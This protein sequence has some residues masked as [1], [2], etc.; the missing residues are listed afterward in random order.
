[1]I[2]NS[3]FGIPFLCNWLP[4]TSMGLSFL[5]YSIATNIII[6]YVIRRRRGILFRDTSVILINLIISDL[7]SCLVVLPHDFAFY[8]LQASFP[9]AKQMSK[10]FFVLKTVMIFLNCNL[11]IVLSIKRYN[12]ATFV[13]RRRKNH[14]SKPLIL[15]LAVI[16][17][18]TLG[19][20]II[21]YRSF[22]DSNRY[23]GNEAIV[24]WIRRLL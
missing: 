4:E 11:T 13:S 17:L 10:A 20:A 3:L 14:L 16:W 8:A 1:M 18:T 19:E 15:C 23:H 24:E 12:T 2:M 5:S 6:L 22:K 21:T 9:Q 7:T